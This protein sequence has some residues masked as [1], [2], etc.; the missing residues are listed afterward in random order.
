M[1]VAFDAAGNPL[2]VEYDLL[3]RKTA[4]ESA[5]TGRYEYVYDMAGNLTEETNSELKA[6][7]QKIRYEYDGM[8]RNTRIVYPETEDTVYEYGQPAAK[9]KGQAGRLVK[10]TDS[11]GTQEFEYGLLGEAVYEKR[12]LKQHGV[13]TGA[14]PA[15]ETRYRSN[16]LGQM[17][18]IDYPDGE[19]V[20]YGY[21]GGGNV[22]SVKGKK[23]STDI[24]YVEK[25]GYDA[26]GQRVYLKLGNGVETKYVYDEKRRWLNSIET[27]KGS[28]KLQGI[29]YAFDPVGNVMGYENTAGTYMT[30]QDYIYDALYQLTSVE[31]TSRNYRNNVLEYT[32]RYSQAYSFDSQGLGNMT[33]KT[34]ATANSN[35]RLL[36]D[37]LDYQFAYEY[38]NGYAHRAK[39]IGE[40]HYQYDRNGNVT[41]EQDGPFEASA[42]TGNTDVKQIGDVNYVEDA[43]GIDSNSGGGGNAGQKYRREYAWDERNRLAVSKDTRYNVQY[44]YDHGG[45]RTGKYAAGT[46]GSRNETLYYSKLWTWTH[47]GLWTDSQGRYSKH[48]FL[49]ES[50]IATKI[51]AGDGHHVP[52]AEELRQYYYHSDHLGSAQLITNYAGEEYERLEYTPYGELWIEKAAEASVLDIAYRFT[53]KE[54]DEETGNYYYGAR[55]LDPRTARWLS[56]DPAMGDYVPSAPINDQARKRN[57]NLPGQGGVFNY[58]NFHV[59]HYAGNNPVK[60]VDPDGEEMGMPSNVER[61]LEKRDARVWPTESTRITSTF[62]QHAANTAGVDVGAVVQGEKG[63]AVNAAM[64]G[65]VTMAGVNP[66]SNSGSTYVT[67]EGHDGK[68][69]RYLHTDVLETTAVG[70]YVETGQEIATMGDNGSPSQIHL[71]FEVFENDQRID[72]VT[73]Y[74]DTT[75]Q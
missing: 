62:N 65:R 30:K 7:G 51:V 55:Y 35:G 70:S 75:F 37:P 43:W 50:R 13:P 74:P 25:I 40:R 20:T 57:G 29:N 66:D 67:I 14:I 68:T 52:R 54:R 59:Y 23:G 44:T 56:T 12:V 6:K 31:G 21:D 69:Y 9:D 47:S 26:W 32:A 2:R 49:G 11:S 60:Y 48:I 64:G 72:P 39:Q 19:V 24:T 53:G 3:G 38:E 46:S 33:L 58:V 41:V 10:V 61:I 22:N 28:T 15:A 36:G 63:D 17:E 45:E 34:S 42:R 1:L 16:Y 18:W 71:H 4:L 8:G 5:D 27:A 73:L